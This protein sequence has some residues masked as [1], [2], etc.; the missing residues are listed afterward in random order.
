MVVE[1]SRLQGAFMRSNRGAIVLSD[2]DPALGRM[3]S[4]Q[5]KR[6]KARVYL[7]EKRAIVPRRARCVFFRGSGAVVGAF[8]RGYFAA[9]V[10]R[11]DLNGHHTNDR[12]GYLVT[13]AWHQTYATGYQER[14]TGGEAQ[15]ELYAIVIGGSLVYRLTNYPE[16]SNLL[17]E[18]A[19]D[20]SP[21]LCTLSD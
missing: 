13:V 15:I 17:P 8:H 5:P 19:G 2:F 14:H 12:N 10:R 21:G 3:V 9:R 16:I 20:V 4:W 7:F 1:Y 11:F 6:D 18:T